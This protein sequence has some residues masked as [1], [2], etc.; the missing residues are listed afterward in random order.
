MTLTRVAPSSLGSP[1]AGEAAGTPA[2]RPPWVVFG[3]DWGRHV[4]TM[5]HLFR[6]MLATDTIVWV[7]SYG[8]RLPQL[9]LYDMGR[10]VRKIQRMLHPQAPAPAAGPAPTRIVHPKALPW[11][12]LRV[13]Q[14]FN[15]RS[16]L[17]DIRRAL[18]GVAPGVAPYFVTGTPMTPGIVGQ[19]A[20]QAAVYFCMDDYAELP[21]VTGN[22]IRPL[23]ERL[24]GRVDGVVATARVLVEKKAP[25]NGRVQYLPQGVNYEHFAE[26]RP[27]PADLAAL[28]RPIVGFAGGVSAACDID[29][30][31]A[32]SDANPTGT[33]ALVGPVSIDTARL[34]R[35][36]IV[37]LGNRPYAELPA[38]VQ[39]FDVGIIPYILN[40]WT[41]AVD[42]LKL[43]EYLAAGI[44]VVSTELPEVLKYREAVHVARTNDDFV[45]E[46]RRALA[47][48]GP[49]D[50]AARQAV[51]FRNTWARR[52]ETLREFVTGIARDRRGAS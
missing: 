48:E 44:P 18:A 16:L 34:Q 5:Q 35:P 49:A 52:G 19:L 17:R 41:R 13:V 51:A 23:E 3:D 15:E 25:R 30:L 6:T 20:E 12:N 38:Y 37:L 32:L 46:V 11:H 27:V 33:V 45:A 2:V 10:A 26:P 4:S 7:N 43:L 31:L 29:L 28:P 42:P 40:D 9:T 24:L 47:G 36:N 1:A 21:G 14:A 22:M 50:R 39:G 8:H